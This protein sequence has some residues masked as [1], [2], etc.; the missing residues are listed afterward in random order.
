MAIYRLLQNSALNPELIAAMSSAYESACVT[1]R[2]NRDADDPFTQL[3]A[4]RIVE[5]CQ[6]GVKDSDV[7]HAR[8]VEEFGQGNSPE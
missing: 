7:I 4:R 3:V 6:T 5:I 1:L 2:L 8:V